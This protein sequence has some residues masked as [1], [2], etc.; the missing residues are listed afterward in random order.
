MNRTASIHPPRILGNPAPEPTTLDRLANNRRWQAEVEYR[1]RLV[2][3]DNG[4]CLGCE[5]PTNDA[6]LIW[7]PPCAPERGM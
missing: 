7:H 2:A 1:R 6:A 4:L 5:Q 3:L